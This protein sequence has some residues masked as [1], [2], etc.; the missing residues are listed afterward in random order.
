MLMFPC[1]VAEL[2]VTFSAVPVVT[3]LEVA[4]SLGSQLAIKHT[5]VAMAK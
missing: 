2:V 4:G 3:L 1:S 5:R